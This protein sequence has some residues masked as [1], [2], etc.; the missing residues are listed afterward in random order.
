MNGVSTFVK[1][2]WVFVRTFCLLVGVQGSR[3][4]CRSG[5]ENPEEKK[6]A[7]MCS[8]EW[9]FLNEYSSSGTGK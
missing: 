1:E 5:V 2:E 7:W 4:L 8:N 6:L 9:F 3:E